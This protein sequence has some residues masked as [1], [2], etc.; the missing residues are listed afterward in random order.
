MLKKLDCFILVNSSE[1][2]ISDSFNE[3]FDF[4]S[5][6]FQLNTAAKTPKIESEKANKNTTPSLFDIRSKLIFPLL[7]IKSNK[8]K[9]R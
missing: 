8:S 7:K 2:R 5:K 3:D 6:S 4:K 1:S 9:K